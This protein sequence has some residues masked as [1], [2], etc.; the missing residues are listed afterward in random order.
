MSDKSTGMLAFA[1]G[2]AAG[3]AAVF[4]SD[5]KNR[6]AAKQKMSDAKDA[7]QAFASDPQAHLQAMVD[8]VKG[9]SAETQE[10]VKRAAEAAKKELAKSPKTKAVAKA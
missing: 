3:A 4:F 9:A 5:A 7:A 10:K 6:D 1:A 8:D 2:L